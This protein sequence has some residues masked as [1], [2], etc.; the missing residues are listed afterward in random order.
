MGNQ[1][2]GR[3]PQPTALTL[4][5]GNPSKKKP[6]ENEPVPPAGEVV[7]PAWLSTGAGVVWDELA[8]VCRHMGTLTPADV[9]PFVTLC[10]LQST[11][12]QASAGK[13]GAGFAPF[14]LRSEDTSDPKSDVIVLIDNVLKLERDT[15]SVLRPYYEYFG[16]TPSSRARIAVPK[17]Q[18]EPA[19]K[20]AGELK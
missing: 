12:Q 17:K 15:A 8:P 5:R 7:K 1:N 3:R 2:S 10:E 14:T 13:D 6:N 16:L 4:L 9:R 20:W 18:A 11:M 19:S